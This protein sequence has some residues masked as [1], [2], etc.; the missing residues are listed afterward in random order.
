MMKEVLFFSELEILRTLATGK[1][2]SQSFTDTHQNA[3]NQENTMWHSLWSGRYAPQLNQYQAKTRYGVVLLGDFLK[4]EANVAWTIFFFGTA[5]GGV[6]DGC[7]EGVVAGGLAAS[8]RG[9]GAV[10]AF[11]GGDAISKM[12]EVAFTGDAIGTGTSA[13]SAEGIAAWEPGWNFS[14]RSFVIPS[15]PVRVNE[16][17]WEARTIEASVMTFFLAGSTTGSSS[18]SSIS[19]KN[20]GEHK[21]PIWLIC[22]DGTQRD[23]IVRVHA[24]DFE[25]HSV[26]IG[27]FCSSTTSFTNQNGRFSLREPVFSKKNTDLLVRLEIVQN[28][29]WGPSI[30]CCEGRGIE[31]AEF[32]WG[33]KWA[34]RIVGATRWSFSSGKCCVN[35]T[36]RKSIHSRRRYTP[37]LQLLQPFIGDRARWRGRALLDAYL[38]V[39][40]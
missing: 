6:E 32:R 40:I 37:G 19:L 15:P 12:A 11:G 5:V 13:G 4:N 28:D 25:A 16:D 22:E 33:A 18:S 2:R 24:S 36:R 9:R 1:Y 38:H 35:W 21:F 17:C 20:K 39:R 8:S 27:F 10:G 31:A 26:C 30:R 7:G 34:V 14:N 29:R 23:N 3:I